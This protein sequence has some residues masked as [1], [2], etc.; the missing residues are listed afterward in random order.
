MK[1]WALVCAVAGCVVLAGSALAAR[2]AAAR[3]RAVLI[4]ALQSTQGEVGIQSITISTVDRTYA[5]VKW[6][7]K[8]NRN[9]LFHLSGARWQSIWNREYTAPADGACAFAPP[10]VVHDLLQ[11]TC[12]NQKALKARSA[13]KSEIGLLVQTFKTSPLTR[14]WR[15][16]TGLK[17]AC[18]SRLNGQWAAAQ[19]QFPGTA[20]ILWF[21]RS[22]Q[23]QVVY[24]TIVG[25]GT[26]PPP[27][28]VL[29]LASCVGYSAADFGG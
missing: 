5:L 7:A 12:P 24:E 4:A 6:G 15:D 1:G 16:S 26:L 10:K 11:V 2:P 18:V 13:T 17:R 29:S 25:R 9:D 23:W 3:E 8:G 21:K 28:V 19:A 27:S 22:S 20:A 14:Y